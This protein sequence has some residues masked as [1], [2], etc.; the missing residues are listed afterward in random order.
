MRTR[1]QLYAYQRRAV[2]FIKNHENCA[3]WADM[4][5]GKTAS[6]ITAIGDLI[7]GFESRRTL[8]VAPL[9][10]ARKVWTD[11]AN[12]WEHLNQMTFSRMVGL[13]KSRRRAL[14]QSADIHCINRENLAWLVDTF[15]DDKGKQK[16]Y[17]PWDTVVLDEAQSF[18][19]QDTVRFKALRRVRKLFPRMIQLTGTPA[20]NGYAGLWSQLFLLDRGKRLGQTESAFRNR[21]FNTELGDGYATYKIKPHSAKEIQERVSDIVLSLKVEDYFDL[22]PVI[23]NPIRVQLRLAD[24]TT[25]RKMERQYVAELVPGRKITAANAAACSTKLLQLANGFLYTGEGNHDYQ[26]FHNEKMLALQEVLEGASGP[27]MIA[28][29]FTADKLRICEALKK[30]CTPTQRWAIGDSDADLGMFAR[31]LIDYLVIHPNMVGHGLNDLHLSG[32]ETIFWFGVTS[33]LEWFQQ[34]N[35]RLIGGIRRIGKNVTIHAALADSTIDLRW[36]DALKAKD[37]TQE[38]LTRVLADRIQ[39]IS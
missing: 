33:N 3:L 17:W 20:P 26:L 7:Q 6:T 12:E 4:G 30:F 29:N 11:E 31:G 27:V 13:R 36:F 22:P 32:S 14:V 19:S 8:V 39:H 16:R 18:K 1:D 10:V 2:E 23:Y 9:R 38:D 21:W 35:A 34:L 25:Y 15:F 5:L 37:A 28:Y 24:I